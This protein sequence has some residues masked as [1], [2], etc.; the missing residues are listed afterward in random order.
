MQQIGVK[1]EKTVRRVIRLIQE[2]PSHK[3]R[4]A[5][6]YV[7]LMTVILKEGD[8]YIN[9]EI[10]RIEKLLL[11]GI[12][13]DKENLSYKKNILKEFLYYIRDEL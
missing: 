4:K 9:R 13:Q 10:D 6:L 3:R 1:R 8:S 5:E 2:L 12:L 7:Q 11:D